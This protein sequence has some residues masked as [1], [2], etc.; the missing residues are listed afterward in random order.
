MST[1]S[2]IIWF[3][4]LSPDGKSFAFDSRANGYGRGEGV[5]TIVIKRLKD[6][7]AAGDPIRAVIRETLL[8]QDGKTDTITTPSRAAQEAL[9]RDC[10][11]KAGVDPLDTQYLEAHGTGTQIGDPLE[12]QAI[13][14]VFRFGRSAQTPLRI[15]SVKTNIGHTEPTSGL[16][17]IIKVALALEH[18]IIPPSL[19]FEKP[20]P[21]LDLDEWRLKVATN[22]EQ[23]PAANDGLRR[24]SVNNFG[25]GGSNA[26]VIME[27]RES[28]LPHIVMRNGTR[29]SNGRQ[30]EI[31]SQAE[32]GN[33]N[34]NWAK[35]SAH[36]TRSMIEINDCT[37]HVEE[38]KSKVLILSAKDEPACQKMVFNLKN[39]LE[40]N[41]PKDVKTFLQSLAYT[42]SE[43]RTL[44]SW[45]AAH[46]VSSTWY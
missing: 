3:R 33:G 37:P 28:W 15:G 4:F 12:A 24:A 30:Y 36:D 8:N 9:I 38:C 25:Y 19:N 13:A 7:V 40:Q 46:P 22:L 45:V 29:E 18:G 17:S 16:A 5:A 26:H 11:R 32:T 42:L 34:E 2:L 1:K 14:D 6:A 44:F 21:R 27:N 41:K 20:N 43:R 23:W 39:F 31:S 10:Y 35:Q